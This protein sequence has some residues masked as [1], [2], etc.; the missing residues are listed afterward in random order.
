MNDLTVV[1]P[2]YNSEKY[3]SKCIDSL[4]KS[5]Y[6]KFDILLIND[7]SKD[8]SLEI[9][10]RYEKK[11]DNIKVINQ[12]NQGVSKTR[13]DAIKNV[14]TKYIMF[15]DNDDFVDEDYIETYYNNIIN[16]DYVVV[17][18]GYRRPNSKGKIVKELSINN[19]YEWSK[20]MITAPWAKIFDREFLVKNNVEFLVN[21]LGEDVYFNL[22]ILM[23]TDKIK[24]IDYIGYNWF[25]NEK[26]VSNSNQK[27]I[28]NLDY[29][30]L[31]NS[32]YDLTKKVDMKISE[33]ILEYFFIRYI[34][35]L[36][37]F[38]VKKLSYR[39]ISKNYDKLFNWLKEKYPNYKKN[40]IVKFSKPKGE[41]KS[42]R[43]FVKI[44]MIFNKLHMGKLLI[45]LYAKI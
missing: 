29:F 4:L 23:L 42:V 19:K 8:K 11:Y 13:N 36:L 43:Y 15:I 37:S 44:L 16:T 41:I 14:K 7:G 5:S 9:L 3:I 38:S 35:W 27:N 20:F 25:F 12:E 2:V 21:N 28:N 6:K 34:A 26:S 17:E 40:N 39:E 45:W 31:L 32:S 1:V 10:R 22:H 24:I 18:G 30:N 33:E